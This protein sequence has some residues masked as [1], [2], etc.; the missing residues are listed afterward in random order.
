MTETDD[1]VADAIVVRRDENLVEFVEV[2]REGVGS[3]GGRI[4]TKP[5]RENSIVRVAAKS[6]AV[7]GRSV[8]N[9]VEENESQYQLLTN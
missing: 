5:G 6:G 4:G 1:V 8:E 3:R 9:K 7:I 2:G